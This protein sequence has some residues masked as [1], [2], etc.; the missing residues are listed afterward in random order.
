MFDGSNYSFTRYLSSKKSV[1]DR[2]LNK[3]VWERLQSVISLEY[4]ANPLKILEIGAG[5]GTMLERSLE[6]GL[7][8]KADYTAI[9][10][11][12]ENIE[13]AKARLQGW[14]YNS[15]YSVEQTSDNELKLSGFGRQVALNL[16]ATDFFE[17]AKH[18]NLTSRWDLI[19]ANAF[20]DLVDA[21]KTLPI[22]LDLLKP[23]GLLY[24]T[25]NF[26]GSTVFEPQI[27]AEFDVVVEELYHR[28]MDERI[29]DGV[30]SGDSKTGRH[31]FQIARENRV[32][33]LESGSSD[34]TVFAGKS[35]Y[36]EDEGYFLHFIVHTMYQA[37]KDSSGLDQD[38]F[39]NWIDRRHSQIEN[40]SLVYIAHQLD[41]L[42]RKER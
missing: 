23:N 2:S 42:G 40:G 9:D 24:F 12:V 4:S 31:F 11:M 35:G 15:G 25:I 18:G 1:D 28:T 17:F 3:V 29:I 10:A 13:E 5:I 38:R 8:A 37:L 41:F 19:I 36:R 30:M 26:D 6:W 34:W 20:L 14:A 39:K 32:E 33:I 16:Q 27:D 21:R 22:T 7:F